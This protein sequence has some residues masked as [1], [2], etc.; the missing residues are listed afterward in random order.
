MLSATLDISC[1]KEKILTD[2]ENKHTIKNKIFQNNPE[3]SE[4][5]CKKLLTNYAFCGIIYIEL[6]KEP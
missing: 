1:K 6:R 4:K 5:T 3:I 2:R